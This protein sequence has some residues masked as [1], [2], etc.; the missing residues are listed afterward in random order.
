[1]LVTLIIAL[2][3][4]NM[5]YCIVQCMKICVNNYLTMLVYIIIMLCICLMLINLYF[6]LIIRICVIILPKSAMRF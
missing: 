6:Y 3:T 1:M 2:K 5:S 4:K